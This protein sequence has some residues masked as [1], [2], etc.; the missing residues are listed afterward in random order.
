MVQVC[1]QKDKKDV[2]KVLRIIGILVCSQAKNLEKMLL[3][4]DHRH[5]WLYHKIKDKF[6]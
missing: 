5:F 4:E 3:V 6:L 1:R 2:H